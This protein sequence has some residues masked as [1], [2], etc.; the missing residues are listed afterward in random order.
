MWQQGLS[1]SFTRIESRPGLWPLAP[2][3]GRY[4]PASQRLPKFG[5]LLQAIP[6]VH[7]SS[8]TTGLSH[9]LSA[10]TA[11]SFLQ[12]VETER[13]A[14]GGQARASQSASLSTTQTR[15]APWLSVPM[16]KV[17]S[18]DATTTWLASG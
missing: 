4:S 12:G 1:A 11:K 17:L 10:P 15:S 7:R 9:W 16:A 18:L 5:T 14:Y 2:M 6:S 3:A 8:M 13:P